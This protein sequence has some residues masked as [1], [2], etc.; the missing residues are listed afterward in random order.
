MCTKLSFIIISIAVILLFT[1]KSMAVT[2]RLAVG[3]FLCNKP[4][5]NSLPS[6]STGDIYFN[7]LTDIMDIPV[8]FLHIPEHI[9]LLYYLYKFL[10]CFKSWNKSYKYAVLTK[11]RI[12]VRSKCGRASFYIL[13]VTIFMV[14]GIVLPPICILKLY[15]DKRASSEYCTQ[16][17]DTIARVLTH[18]FHFSSFFTNTIIVLVRLLMIVFTIM[19]GVMWREVKP[20]STPIF[21]DDPHQETDVSTQPDE[22]SSADPTSTAAA[23]PVSIAVADPVSTAVAKV[24]KR[25]TNYMYEYV[26]ITKKAAPIYTIFSS[27]FVLQWIIHL[28]GLFSHIAHLLRPWIRHGQVQNANTLIVTQQIDQFCYTV[29]HALALVITHICGLKMNAYLRRYI[30]EVHSHQLK[31]PKTKLT[32]DNQKVNASLEYSLTYLFPIKEE[33]VYMSNFTP[34][35]PGTGLGISI[36]NP[37]FVV[38]IVLSI[39]ALIGS[40]IAF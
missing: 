13:I 9:Y 32:D 15:I 26:L 2:A 40:M 8:G 20:T 34:R 16:M 33:S 27:F 38:S 35:I 24:C 7:R 37:A 29:F 17:L 39:F 3:E 30:R 6:N 10:K 31:D 5:L 1:V 21:N 11:M 22:T 28:F 18:V 25:H 36:S 19:I 23:D 4:S 14:I 12:F